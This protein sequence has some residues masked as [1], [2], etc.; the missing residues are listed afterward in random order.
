MM[1]RLNPSEHGWM[2]ALS[3]NA[4][5]DALKE[6]IAATAAR[7]VVEEGLEYGAA[8]RPCVHGGGEEGGELHG[9]AC[10]GW[11]RSCRGHRYQ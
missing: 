8:K 2:T 7:M 10:V 11:R 1:L 3:T 9:D 4:V 5:M 6:E